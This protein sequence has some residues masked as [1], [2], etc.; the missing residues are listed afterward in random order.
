MPGLELCEH[1]FR[2]AVRPLLAVHLTTLMY[3]A[4]RRDED[5]D[6]LGFDPPQ[7]MEHGWGPAKLVLYLEDS[8]PAWPTVWESPDW[9]TRERRLSAGYMARRGGATCLDSPATSNPRWR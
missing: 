3:A 6:V 4:A 8:D 1:V 2:T 9:H 5:S 7:S